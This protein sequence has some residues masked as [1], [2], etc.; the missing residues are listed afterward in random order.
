MA[1]VTLEKQVTRM[2]PWDGTSFPPVAF[3]PFSTPSNNY[4]GYSVYGNLS[5]SSVMVTVMDGG[6]QSSFLIGAGVP[7]DCVI[8]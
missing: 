6:N 3:P 4:P 7:T 2:S 5:G 8:A 1:T